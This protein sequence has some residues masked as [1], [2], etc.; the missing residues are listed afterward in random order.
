MV[1]DCVL[2]LLVV[3]DVVIV[4]VMVKDFMCWFILVGEFVY[5][6]VVVLY[7]GVI[8]GWVLLSFVLYV[9]L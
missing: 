1:S 9:I 4:I 7:G 3:M 2:G 5:V 8:D 6:V